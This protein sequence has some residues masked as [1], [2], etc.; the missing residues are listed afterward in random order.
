MVPQKQAEEAIISGNMNE[1][2]HHDDQREEEPEDI[3]SRLSFKRLLWHGGSVYDAWFSCASNQVILSK[4]TKGD[5][6]THHY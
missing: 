3:H 5:E 2:D 1:N 4:K 6:E